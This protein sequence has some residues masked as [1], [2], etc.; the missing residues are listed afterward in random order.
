MKIIMKI[1]SIAILLFSVSYTST[2]QKTLK[3][4]SVIYEIT[5]IESDAPEAQMMKGSRMNLYF[6]KKMQKFEMSMM[7]GLIEIATITNVDSEESTIL[8]NMMGNKSMVKMSKEEANQQKAK[9]EKPDYAVTY[10]KSDKKEIVGYNC[11]KAILTANDGTSINAYVSDEIKTKV[12]FFHEMFP[13]LNVFPLEFSI[14][15]GEMSM[16]FSAQE[17]NKKVESTTFDIPSEGYTQMTMEEFEKQMGGMGG[18]GF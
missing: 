9:N 6:N 13:G 12:K 10:D 4:G 14:G 11:Y 18:M 5:N 8:T 3:E 2:A 7:G 16:V 17:F 1:T 15:A